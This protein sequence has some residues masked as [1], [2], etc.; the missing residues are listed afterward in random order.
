L[1]RIIRRAGP[2]SAQAIWPL[3]FYEGELQLVFKSMFL[4]GFEGGTG[5]NKFGAWFDGVSRTGHDLYLNE[6]YAL[7]A[8]HNLGAVRESV[9]WP[10][11]DTPSGYDFSTLDIVVDAG[12]RAGIPTIFDLFHFGYPAFLDLLSDEFTKRFA[13]YSYQVARRVH[14]SG[15]PVCY[16]APVNEPSYFAWAAGEMGLFAPY[17]RGRGDDIKIALVR[18]AIAGTEA[19]WAACPNAR[20]I[21]VDPFCHVV[22]ASDTFEDRLRAD[23]FNAATVFHSWDMLAG[24]V[25]PELGGSPRHLDIVGVNYYQ[26]NQWIMGSP[27]PILGR[28]DERRLGLAEILETVWRRYGRPLMITETSDAGDLRPLWIHTLSEEIE[29]T[30][31]SRIPLVGVCWYPLLEMAEWHAPDQWTQMGL[32]DVDHHS[33]SMRRIP[34]KPALRALRQ[35]E[36]RLQPRRQWGVPQLEWE[37]S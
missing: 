24:V 11:V 21:S 14:R 10:L 31:L 1:K 6:D 17:L 12:R 22:P 5:R 26:T 35:A 23:T 34:F 29:S 28:Y 18:A 9:R 13:E 37:F 32:W 15:G 25:M 30:L 8:E 7:A 16:F 19:I 4:G 3:L 2:W 27:T 36:E 33:G 20:I